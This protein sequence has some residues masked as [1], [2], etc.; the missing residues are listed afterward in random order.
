MLI[1]IIGDTHI[2]C[3]SY[4]QPTDG[5]GNSRLDDY[6]KTLRSTIKDLVASGVKHIL[7]TGDIFEHRW[8][9]VLQQKI[10]SEEI[11]H[12]LSIGVNWIGICLGNHDLTRQSNA[13][14]LSYIQGLKLPAVQ[15]YDTMDVVELGDS[16]SPR[17]NVLMMPFRDRKNL[18]VETNDAALELV[19]KEF[20][21]VFDRRNQNLPT[22][23]LGHYCIEGTIF[24]SEDVDFYGENQLFLPQALFNDVELSIFGHIHEPKVLSTNPYIAYVG[25]MEKRSGS[26][27]HDKLYAIVDTE[28]Q[29]VE[30]RKEPCREI[31]EIKLDYSHISLIDRLFDRIVADTDEFAEANPM[32]ESIVKMS[33]KITATDDKYVEP[34]RIY[35]MLKERHKIQHCVELHPELYTERQARNDRI[36]ELIGDTE[37]FR[38]YLETVIDD[39]EARAEISAIG[40]DI[41][42]EVEAQDAAS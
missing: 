20:R 10:F 33:L 4:G 39:K 19:A 27:R 7:F 42:R 25:S 28:T 36:T 26:E 2:G 16:T 30:Y 11:S 5:G 18:G 3:L 29:S 37:A 17:T 8:P 14:S 24:E 41:I 13:S 9:T 1:G 23:V 34:K 21:E 12:A 22:L 35:R 31:Y 38:I 15:I 40:V 6:R 32:Q